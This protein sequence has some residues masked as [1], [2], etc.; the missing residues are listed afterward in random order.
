MNRFGHEV[1]ETIG[2]TIPIL[3]SID[4]GITS[5]QETLFGA[6]RADIDGNET[7][8]KVID[9]LKNVAASTM[10]FEPTYKPSEYE[11]TYRQRMENDKKYQYPTD[12]QNS[13][14]VAAKLQSWPSSA[15]RQ[16]QELLNCEKE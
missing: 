11:R 6:P 5:T 7:K 10:P 2:E 4:K 12:T 8:G 9:A 3:G 1:R 14:C 13:K 16:Y 15:E